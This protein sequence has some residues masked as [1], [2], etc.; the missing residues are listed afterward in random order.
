MTSKTEM[1]WQARIK[2][3]QKTL[4]EMGEMRPGSLSMQ[5]NV[6]GNPSCRCKDKENPQKHGPYYQL[7]Y[8]HKGKSTTEFVKAEKVNEVRQQIQNFREFKKLTEQWVDLSVKIA[9]LRKKEAG[10]ISK[11]SSR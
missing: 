6:C 4:S 10:K 3:I 2:E 8:T 1:K 7:S 5:Y 11:R 9:K